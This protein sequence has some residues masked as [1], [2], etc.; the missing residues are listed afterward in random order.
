M[1]LAADTRARLAAAA[2]DIA[3]PHVT[4][5]FEQAIEDRFAVRVHACTY[6]RL[7]H[8]PGLAHGNRTGAAGCRPLF[9]C[10]SIDMTQSSQRISPT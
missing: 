2:A 7:M 4:A 1:R 10:K 9:P 5:A 6:F 3:D 8:V